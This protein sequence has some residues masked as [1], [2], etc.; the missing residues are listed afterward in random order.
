MENV[1]IPIILFWAGVIITGIGLNYAFRGGFMGPILVG[2]GYWL[3]VILAYNQLPNPLVAPVGFPIWTANAITWCHNNNVICGIPF[4][5]ALGAIAQV[6]RDP[7]NE[8]GTWRSRP[9]AATGGTG[10]GAGT[11]G[12]AA[13]A[14]V[15]TPG[16]TNILYGMIALLVV[17]VISTFAVWM[18]YGNAKP[19]I[20]NTDV[21]KLAVTAKKYETVTGE[22]LFV[23]QNPAFYIRIPESF[24]QDSDLQELYKEL[25]KQLAQEG[26]DQGKLSG[27]KKK[28]EAKKIMAI[29]LYSTDSKTIDRMTFE[30]EGKITDV[31][32]RKVMKKQSDG[33][34][35][36]ENEDFPLPPKDVKMTQPSHKTFDPQESTARVNQ[37]IERMEERMRRK[38][39]TSV[40]TAPSIPS[41]GGP[42][43]KTPPFC[44][45][46]DLLP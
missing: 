39:P 22:R 10:G 33:S 30:V 13:A 16:Q 42:Q 20:P 5:L 3:V 24:L 37:L 40:G 11:G 41:V 2:V 28:F 21:T 31:E 12:A 8:V 45:P 43:I 18:W 19:A 9:T 26:F 15:V 32:T 29:M 17:M 7:L 14:T 1:L 34:M 46:N 4:V 36:E 6:W 35:K 27:S 38:D 25:Y 44:S 23:T